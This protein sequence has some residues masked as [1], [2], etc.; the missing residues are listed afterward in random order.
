LVVTDPVGQATASIGFGEGLK[1]KQTLSLGCPLV[2]EALW[3]Q[4]G[5]RKTLQDIEKAAGV[6]VPYERA[7]LAWWPSGFVSPSP[8]SASGVA[9]YP[10]FTC[11]PAR[12]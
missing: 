9:G 10:R 6:Q 5:L 8:N 7:L 11:P 1:I 2:V 3:E 12:D 4:L